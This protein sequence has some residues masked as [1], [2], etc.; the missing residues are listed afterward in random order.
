MPVLSAEEGDFDKRTRDMT[1]EDVRSA[2]ELARKRHAHRRLR[3]LFECEKD[4]QPGQVVGDL[5]VPM[6]K[7][8]RR[9][10]EA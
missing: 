2:I 3:L 7:R 8:S 6:P 9:K 10:V 5:L 4:L 1:I